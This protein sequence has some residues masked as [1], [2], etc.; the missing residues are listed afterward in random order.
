MPVAPP[1]PPSQA[2]PAI[3]AVERTGRSSPAG[4]ARW[5]TSQFGWEAP[6][7][8]L[9]RQVPPTGNVGEPRGA[10][11]VTMTN[12][13]GILANGNHF[14]P[15]CFLDSMAGFSASRTWC[16]ESTA[17]RLPPCCIK[18]LAVGAVC[19]VKSDKNVDTAGV[20][21]HKSQMLCSMQCFRIQL[22]QAATFYVKVIR[23]STCR[24]A[25]KCIDCTE[26]SM[27][28]QEQS[29]NV[30]LR[31]GQ[32]TLAQRGAHGNWRS[33]PGPPQ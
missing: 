15:T 30:P 14:G 1:T 8:V 31:Q 25:P 21:E 5:A 26:S 11:P 9:Q 18:A 24:D 16:E 10:E 6:G 12:A 4:R 29:G 2:P 27:H 17:F 7:N 13:K 33:E 23:N 3:F 32:L 28:T 20:E 19:E 22:T